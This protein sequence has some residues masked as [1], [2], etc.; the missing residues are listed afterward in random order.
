MQ[1]RSSQLEVASITEVMSVSEPDLEGR[2]Q[3]ERVG[4]MGV[5]IEEDEVSRGIWL[6]W[7]LEWV[8]FGLGRRY[9]EGFSAARQPD[10]NHTLLHNIICITSL[11]RYGW[12]WLSVTALLNWPSCV[13]PFIRPSFLSSSV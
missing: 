13:V 5:G 8:G 4:G 12:F 7:L 6:V 10:L 2:T 11:Q 1:R 9:F 3:G